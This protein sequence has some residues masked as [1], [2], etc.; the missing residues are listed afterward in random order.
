MAAVRSEVWAFRF[1]GIT[2]AHYVVGRDN[3][4][5]SG[6]PPPLL[7]H[8]PPTADKQFTSPKRVDMG[9]ELDGIGQTAWGERDDMGRGGMHAQPRSYSLAS[10]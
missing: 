3:D 10:Q 5:A 2:T 4:R 1:G 9:M 6:A 8:T 7:S